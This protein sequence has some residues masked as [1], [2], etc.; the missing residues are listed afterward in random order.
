MDLVDKKNVVLRKIG[1]QRHQISR[2]L[3][4]RAGGD[5][6]IHSHFF[7]NDRRKSGLSKARR[8]VEQHMIQTFLPALC[9]LHIDL[10][11][12]LD[13]VL[14][15][16]F[17]QPF[18]AKAHFLPIPRHLSGTDD[19]A[20]KIKFLSLTTLE[21]RSL[22]CI[23]FSVFKTDGCLGLSQ[24][25]PACGFAEERGRNIKTKES[26]VYISGFHNKVLRQEG[27]T[28]TSRKFPKGALMLWI[29]SSVPL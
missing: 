17:V 2:T 3:N 19:P 4:G 13:L 10:Q 21:H 27:G 16:I 24:A 7:G 22:L 15:H 8:A 18:G 20:F 1:Q 25:Y 6:Q 12:F 9:R 14:P 26:P 11:V 5:P 29:K 28:G 23:S